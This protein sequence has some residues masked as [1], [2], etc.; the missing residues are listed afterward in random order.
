M[1]RK[2]VEHKIAIVI[3][4]YKNWQDTV[5]CLMSVI[6]VTYRPYR[7]IV[8]DNDS[9]NSS[10]THIC[11]YLKQQ[12]KDYLL[13][14]QEQSEVDEVVYHPLV[15]IQSKS[16]RGYAAGNNIGIRWAVRSNDDYIMILNN[17]TI[18][19]RDFLEPLADFLNSHQ[20]AAM[21][22]PK[23]LDS[24]G[25][26]DRNCARRRPV[27]REYLFRFGLLKKLFPRNKWVLRHYYIGEYD[28][29]AP[30][31]VDVLAGSCMMIRSSIIQRMNYLD[32]TT[33]LYLE[34]FILSEKLKNLHKKVFIN[35]DSVITH[36]QGASVK[37]EPSLFILKKGIESFYYYLTKY[38][39]V[40]SLVALIFMHSDILKYYYRKTKLI[41]GIK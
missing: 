23:I 40:P 15:L 18:V 25:R 5:E 29:N 33:F 35:P 36:K 30:R 16:N 27:L 13:L 4:N 14:T 37:N 2:L 8:V 39:R 12:G 7:I 41:V 11:D 10:L 31:E 1:E 22:G 34:E 6:D 24:N 19:Q 28:F 32:E 17:D 26:I 9:Q 38:R 20:D 3:L 21:V